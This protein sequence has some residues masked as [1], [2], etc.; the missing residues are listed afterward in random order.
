MTPVRAGGTAAG[1]VLAGGRDTD[2]VER[3]RFEPV[4]RARQG[5]DGADLDRVPREVGVE[6]FL[7]DPDLLFSAPLHEI[8]QRV[9]GDLV[10][11]PGAALA[12]HTAFA[13]E[14]HL[15]ADVDGL[16]E[17]ALRQG[18]PAG[19]PSGR[20]G[21][22]LQRAF[23]ALVAHGA[24]QRMVGQQELHH[25]LL[26]DLGLGAG[27]L[28]LDL[29]VLGDI[30]R[31]GGLWLGHAFDLDQTLAAGG[32]RVQ[33]RMVAEPGDLDAHL[34]GG[35]DD[36]RALRYRDRLAVDEG[37]HEVGVGGLALGLCGH[38]AAPARLAVSGGMIIVAAGGKASSTG[39]C[40]AAS[41]SERN[42]LSAGS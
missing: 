14:Q 5:A 42:A 24:V 13:I 37:M 18:V 21:L 22:V 8:D 9:T 16:R 2:Q 32:H 33:Q 28:G 27:V 29:H 10:G 30:Q 3:A 35:P 41:N 23:P 17:R 26:G 4:V 7:A 15:C 40:R 12:V 19:G 38:V 39:W 36:E 11:E 34:L 1:T 20:H 6:R 31:A 25:A